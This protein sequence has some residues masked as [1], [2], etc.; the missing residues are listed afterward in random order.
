MGAKALVSGVIA[1]VPGSA[2]MLAMLAASMAGLWVL[3]TARHTVAART[4]SPAR[5]PAKTV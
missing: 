1:V 4:A 3:A 2:A 5:R